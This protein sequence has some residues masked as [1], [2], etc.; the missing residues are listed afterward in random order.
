MIVSHRHKFIFIHL[1]R[2]GGRSLTKALAAHC[3]PEDIITRGAG[4][5][6]QNNKG[7][8]RHDTALQIRDGIG[9]E[10]FD[11]YFKFCIERNPW[12]KIISRYWDY[13]GRHGR[14]FYKRIPLY[15]TGKPLSFKTWF[16]LRIAQGLVFGLGHYRFPRHFQCYTENDRPIVDFIGR[17][18]H[19]S[20]HLAVLSDRLGFRVAMEEQVGTAYHRERKPYTELFDARMRRIVDKHFAKDLAF[21]GYRFGE[22]AP[23]DVIEPF[24]RR[25]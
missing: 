14:S 17:Y 2:T 23:A 7:F 8:T 22:P 3:G 20:D 12:D 19:L 24:G 25:P 18:E 9:R 15:L 16:D 5:P 11:S 10:A 6:A 4:I 13:A 21:L 1:G